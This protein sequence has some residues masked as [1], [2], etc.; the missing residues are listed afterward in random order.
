MEGVSE[1]SSER[2]YN[3]VLS[4]VHLFGSCAFAILQA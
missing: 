1:I 4:G 3:G 2:G